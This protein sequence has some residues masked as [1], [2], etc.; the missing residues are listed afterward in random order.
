MTVRRPAIALAMLQGM[1]DRFFTAAHL[2]RL[3]EVGEV[4]D[5]EPLST[6]DDDRARAVLARTEVLVGHW[7]CPTLTAEAL[8]LA[9]HLQVL[10][11]G[12]GTVKWQVTDALWDRGIVVTSAA[13]ANAVPVAEYTVAMVLLAGKGVLLFRETLRD[14]D[15][16]VRVDRRRIGTYG[17][18][19]GIV[20][21]SHV[22]RLV[23][24]RLRPFDIDVSVYDP[25][26]DDD[27]ARSLGVRLERDLVALC[28]WSD[29]LSLH[30]P[31]IAST[32]G[33]LGAP[34]FA[35]LRDGATF[36]NTARPALVD[37]EALLVHLRTGRIAAVLDVADPDPPQ[38]GHELLTLPNVFCTPHVAGSMGSEVFR[39]SELAVEEVERWARGEA[40]RY[41]VRRED[42]DRIA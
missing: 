22:G 26:L 1:R 10:A 27:G 14:P 39:M 12:A 29:V 38:P 13:A 37:Q 33:M 7:G 19:L 21:A 6:F 11:Y 30:A 17:L 16:A 40:L 28:A 20:G 15:A 42:L 8:A 2:A 36:I 5:D 32:R 34:H 31:D 3:R 9:P 41:P 35:A 24:E 25:F 4:L 23:I 18:R